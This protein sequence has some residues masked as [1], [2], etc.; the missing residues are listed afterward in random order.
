MLFLTENKPGYQAQ[1]QMWLDK[2]ASPSVN[3]AS[4]ELVPITLPASYSWIESNLK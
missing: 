3:L 2:P 1:L 4:I